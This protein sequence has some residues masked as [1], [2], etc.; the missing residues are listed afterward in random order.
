MRRFNPAG[1]CR[2]SYRSAA[3]PIE[4]RTRFEDHVTASGREVTLLR[5]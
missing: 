1:P 5:A 2:P 4:D 3:P